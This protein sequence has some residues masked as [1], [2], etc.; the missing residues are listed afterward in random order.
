M[1]ATNQVIEEAQFRQPVL[2]QLIKKSGLQGQEDLSFG[3]L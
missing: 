2:M 1:D 3:T